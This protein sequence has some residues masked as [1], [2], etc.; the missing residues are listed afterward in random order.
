VNRTVL[1]L[2][3]LTQ[4]GGSQRT[5]LLPILRFLTQRRGSLTALYKIFLFNWITKILL[6]D[7]IKKPL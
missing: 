7:L 1:D 2:G 4:E 3:V 6:G 5:I